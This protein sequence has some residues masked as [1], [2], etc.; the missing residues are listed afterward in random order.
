DE[1]F[2]LWTEWARLY[3]P[4]ASELEADTRRLLEQV[5]D[6]YWLV[7]IVHNDYQDQE[8]IWRLFNIGEKGPEEGLR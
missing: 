3:D 6:T 4:E 8:A 5:R 2:Q 7:N 1:A